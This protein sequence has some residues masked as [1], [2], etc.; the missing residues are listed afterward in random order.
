MD[1]R[2]FGSL[3]RAV[4]LRRNLRQADLAAAAGVSGSAVSRVE[5]GDLAGVSLA[6]LRRI[7]AP[8]SI[9][10]SLDGWWRGGDGA[11]L[12]NRRHSLLAESFTRYAAAF[13]GWELQAEVSF[14]I[15]GERG[16]IDQLGWH[17]ARHHLLVVELKTEFV[18]VNEMLG[19]LDRKVRLA[20]RIATERGLAA[21]MISM[22]LVV[23]DSRTNR[24]AAA[25]HR[26]LLAGRFEL[27]GR[28][29]AAFLRRP[30]AATTGLAFWTDAR[31]PGA[32]Q[33]TLAP[34]KA[35]R[36]CKRSNRAGS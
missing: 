23:A 26:Q 14:A 33:A 35:V 19:T 30:S 4:R 32:I 12:L 10:V 24:R 16:S 3:V 36:P 5:C 21:E 2:Q 28:S 22:W 13:P 1:D 20:R 7:A 29:L 31:H 9:H 18:D 34:P 11:R 27:D 6:A 8:L 25:E 17:E 15:Y